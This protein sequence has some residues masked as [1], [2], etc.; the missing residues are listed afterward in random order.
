[1]RRMKLWVFVWKAAKA[2]RPLAKDIAYIKD[3]GR[4]VGVLSDLGV[5]FHV[6][7]SYQKLKLW[8]GT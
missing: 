1:M 8:Q 6:V 5:E 3:P 4:I 2:L 7:D